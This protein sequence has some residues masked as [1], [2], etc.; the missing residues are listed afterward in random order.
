MPG[1]DARII[2]ARRGPVEHAC[3]LLAQPALP[4]LD[5]ALPELD[6]NTPGQV[7]AS[8][9]EL[10]A[11]GNPLAPRCLDGLRERMQRQAAAATNEQSPAADP[12][13]AHAGLTHAAP[14]DAA[15]GACIHV[16]QFHT[17]AGQSFDE[18]RA[19]IESQRQVLNALY[20]KRPKA[21]FVEGRSDIGCADDRRA[22]AELVGDAF[23]GYR[24]GQELEVGQE[25]QLLGAS[26]ALIYALQHPEVE[27]RGTTTDA[28]KATLDAYMQTHGARIQ[29][30]GRLNEE[31]RQTI[32][33]RREHLAVSLVAEWRD[34]N[35]GATA[36]I[37]FGGAHDFK[38]YSG[39]LG[40]PVEAVDAVPPLPPSQPQFMPGAR[41]T[42][43]MAFPEAQA[44]MRSMRPAGGVAHQVARMSPAELDAHLEQFPMN[45]AAR[46]KRGTEADLRFVLQH[47]PEQR[48]ALARLGSPAPEGDAPVDRP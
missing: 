32:L 24:A 40:T 4:D 46:L 22:G 23:A 15:E 7:A 9:A 18:R 35:P 13:T 47:D 29:Q 21:V 27:L 34:R 44:D 17:H 20:D 2:S 45:V 43:A 10:A 16:M 33:A 5:T 8:L 48:E 28:E 36:A 26:G 1:I 42:H 6:G 37:V 38:K 12:Q 19:V 25:F 11:N 39:A 41:R 30:D 14:R 31:D 3:F